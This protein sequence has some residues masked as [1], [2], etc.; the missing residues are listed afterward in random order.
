MAM[1]QHPTTNVGTTILCADGFSVNKDM[2]CTHP[3]LLHSIVSD[4]CWPLRIPVSAAQ[5]VREVKELL[6][7]QTATWHYRCGGGTA[8]LHRS[9]PATV[10]QFRLKVSWCRKAH[11]FSRVPLGRPHPLVRWSPRMNHHARWHKPHGQHGCVSRDSKRP[12]P[13]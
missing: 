8:L 6:T 2:L 5:L 12:S 10:F 4:G 1:R 13:I 11:E 3:G 7:G 9:S